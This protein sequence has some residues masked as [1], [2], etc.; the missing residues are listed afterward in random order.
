MTSTTTDYAHLL[1]ES[2][3]HDR[4]FVKAITTAYRQ[5]FCLAA[6]RVHD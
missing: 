6:S 1:G 5:A 4:R 3:S 2:R